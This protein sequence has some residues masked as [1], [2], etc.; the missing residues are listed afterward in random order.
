[1]D[2][3]N[4]NQNQNNNEDRSQPS[5]KQEP[6][7]QPAQK[8]YQPK[9]NQ[10]GWFPNKGKP[11]PNQGG[12]SYKPPFQGGQ[13][14]MNKGGPNNKPWGY[15]PNQGGGNMPPY[16]KMDP[17]QNQWQGQQGQQMPQQNMYGP[18]MNSNMPPQSNM[19]MNQNQMPPWMQN[20]QSGNNG[21]SPG[22]GSNGIPRE[23]SYIENILR[24][25]TGKVATFYMTFE[26]NQAWNDKTFTGVIQEAGKDHIVI[27]D[28][29]TGKW[30][31]LLMI[32]LDYVEFN[33]EINYQYPFG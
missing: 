4:Q 32:Y 9:Q 7:K 27:E 28:T 11:S 23:Q 30:Y 16:Q 8:P 14:G 1:M 5:Y 18:P 26:N 20:N 2:Q 3:S 19:G 24:L 21:F 25:N 13:P 22:G 17:S 29:E 6:Y 10:Q 15:N 12:P 33:E 31:L